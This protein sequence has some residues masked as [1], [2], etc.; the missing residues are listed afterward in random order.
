[1]HASLTAEA[2]GRTIEASQGRWTMIIFAWVV[3]IWGHWRRCR[4]RRTDL[5]IEDYG[6]IGDMQTW[7]LVGRDGGGAPGP[8][9]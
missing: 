1:M 4:D 3:W 7:A 5:R 9:L 2:G 8:P 6:F